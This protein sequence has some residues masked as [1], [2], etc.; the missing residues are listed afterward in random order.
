M[1]QEMDR[2]PA[3]EGY[4][5][6]Y[7]GA[8]EGEH[9]I[10]THGFIGVSEKEADAYLA[11]LRENGFSKVAENQIKNAVFY[12][13]DKENTRVR[14]A[15]YPELCLLK[16]VVTEGEFFPAAP[17]PGE[18]K[19]PV[20]I[21]QIARNGARFRAPGMSYIVQAQDGSFVIIDGGCYEEN[22]AKELLRFLTE[23]NP[24]EGKPVIAA[25]MITHPHIDHMGLALRF[26]QDYHE[27][28]DLRMIAANFPDVT[29]ITVKREEVVNQCKP[30]ID[31]FRELTFTHFPNAKEYTFH[32]GDVW[33]LPG[34]RMDFLFTQED[35][36]PAEFSFV[37]HLSSAWMIRGEK[38]SALILGDCEKPLCRQMAAAYGSALKCDV[39]Q[40]SHHGFNGACLELY[41][42]ADPD[43]CFFACDKERFLTDPRPQ[44][45]AFGYDFN[46]YLRNPTIKERRLCHSEE[47][48][49]ICLDTK[50]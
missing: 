14:V 35:F 28:V 46:A 37:N 44:G 29:K 21:T 7:H 50:E 32:T 17:E 45:Q 49:T 10:V 22:D 36:Y 43:V 3:F 20:S 4:G 12:T 30:L 16:L 33:H 2:L 39:L 42:H 40:L 34:I 15:F 24:N 47:T 41:R 1:K 8:Y 48:V 6:C 27:E 25:W 23:N 9:G 31:R 18:K 13:M 38:R 11:V 5:Y 26:L 19:V